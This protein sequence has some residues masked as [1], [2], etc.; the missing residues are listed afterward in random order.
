MYPIF[1]LVI[2]T[3]FPKWT[4]HHWYVNVTLKWHLSNFKMFK[5]YIHFNMLF[6]KYIIIKSMI[7]KIF[8]D[9]AKWKR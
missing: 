2:L 7:I 3:H 8:F 5:F 1:I 9:K 4:L 6:K